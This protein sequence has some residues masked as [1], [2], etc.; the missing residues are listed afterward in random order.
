MN[1][2]I[3]LDKE[4]GKYHYIFWQHWHA[5]KHIVSLLRLYLLLHLLS[6]IVE[7]KQ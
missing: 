7:E 2:R 1:T 3:V 6:N 5:V 4:A